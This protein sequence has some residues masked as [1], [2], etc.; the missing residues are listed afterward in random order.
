VNGRDRLFDL[1]ADRATQSLSPEEQVELAGLLREHPGV[2]PDALD[3]VA[4]ALDL[5][6]GATPTEPLPELLRARIERAASGASVPRASASAQRSALFG[7]VGWAVAAGLLLFL[8]GRGG[9]PAPIPPPPAEARAALLASAPD[10]R[11]IAWTRTQDPA[12]ASAEGDVVWSDSRQEGY[13]RFRGLPAND[14][15]ASQYQLW[16]FDAERDERYPVDG[17]VFDVAASGETVVTIRA[18]LPVARATLFAITVEKPGGVVVSD[19]S[20]LP[21][22]AKVGG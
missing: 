1:L 18:K 2:D 19:R 13:L 9:P 15:R 20:R 7:G 11:A 12:A 17:G 3:R 22:L 10:A 6:L 14:A 21:L 5:S 8:L 16:I 4:A